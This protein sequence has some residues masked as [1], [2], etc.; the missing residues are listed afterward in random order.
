[1]KARALWIERPGCATL[2]SMALCAPGP[3][4][5]L[6]RTLH[7]GISR[8]TESLVFRGAVPP[9]LTSIM[10]CPFQEGDFPGPVKYGYASVGRIEAGDG[11]L[12]QVVFCL[13]P[14]QDRYVVPRAAVHVLPAGVP[15]GRAVLAANLETALNGVWDA[16]VSPGDVVSVIGGGVVGCLVA[17]LCSRIV[18]CEVTLSDIDPGRANIASSLGVP[19]SL[20]ETAPGGCDVVFHAS[21][22]ASGLTTALSLAGFEAT[23]IEL[24]WYGTDRVPLPLGEHFHPNRLTIRSSQVGAIPA[25]RRPRWDFKR[26]LQVVMRLLQEP[27]LDTLIDGTSPFSALPQTLARL[28]KAPGALCH[29]IDYEE[30]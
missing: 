30:P 14:H 16:G 24:S 6:V 26:R 15:P 22:T 1:M 23:I 25:S 28:S 4:D 7:S 17:W 27:C 8:G 21:G 5:V 13:Y 19:F 29:R 2:R 11:P 20:P 10:R 18:G 9:T 3:G 12:G